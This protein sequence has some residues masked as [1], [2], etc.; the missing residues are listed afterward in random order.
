MSGSIRVPHPANE[1]VLSYAPGT[2]ERAALEAALAEQAGAPI[3]IPLVIGGQEVRT[4][5]T[6]HAV[7]P[8]D[9]GHVLATWHMAGPAEVKGAIAAAKQA[10]GDWSTMR[11]EDR[12]AVFLRAAELLSTTWRARVN[13]ATMLG[14]SKTAHQAEIDSACELI[15]FFRFNAWFAERIH[16]DQPLSSTGVWNRSEY[17]P[18]EGWR[19]SCTRSRPST[20]PR[21]RA[22]CR[23]P[24]R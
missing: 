13:A 23:A 24:R 16:D 8:H 14:Q 6:A 1:P 3:E 2:P 15:D 4:G 9:H 5:R 22:T 7:M 17:R 18:L 11:W 21:S 10:W 19:A 12:A 20:S